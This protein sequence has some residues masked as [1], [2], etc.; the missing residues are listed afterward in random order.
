LENLLERKT[1]SKVDLD[2]D[3]P[4][5]SLIQAACGRCDKKTFQSLLDNGAVAHPGH[6]VSKNT[7]DEVVRILLQSGSINGDPQYE[8]WAVINTCMSGQSVIMKM[9][10]E[11]DKSYVNTIDRD[12]G[13]PL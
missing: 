8:T 3:D 6:L 7:D 4:D 9:L 1:F 10:I 13:P 11:H 5:G 12:Y 2:K